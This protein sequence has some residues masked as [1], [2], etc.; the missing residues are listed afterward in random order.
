MDNPLEP[1]PPEA[2]RCKCVGPIAS[3]LLVATA[4]FASGMGFLRELPAT[5]EATASPTETI[6]ATAT[7]TPAPLDVNDI[8]FL[9]P[10]PQTKADV[11]ALISLDDQAADGKLFSDELLN[12]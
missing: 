8:S 9:W 1:W 2:K 4:F 10:V 12:K 7:P 3:F 5:P 11:D 6:T